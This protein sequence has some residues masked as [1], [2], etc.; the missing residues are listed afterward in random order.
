MKKLVDVTTALFP[1]P[2]EKNAHEQ[3]RHRCPH[4]LPD[5]HTR[6]GAFLREWRHDGGLHGH[7]RS[8]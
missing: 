6:S 7:S 4:A 3:L 1:F 5:L 8:L 2:V